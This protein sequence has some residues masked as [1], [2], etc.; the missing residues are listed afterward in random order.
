MTWRPGQA[1]ASNDADWLAW[2]EAR[3]LEQ[4]RERRQRYP[5]LTTT[6]GCEWHGRCSTA[7]RTFQGNAKVSANLPLRP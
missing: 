5:G 3:K 2:R 7:R 6:L 1:S 4:Q